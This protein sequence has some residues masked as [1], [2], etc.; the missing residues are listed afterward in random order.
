MP[1]RGYYSCEAF[2][3]RKKGFAGSPPTSIEMQVLPPARTKHGNLPG[4]HGFLM[5][6]KEIEISG[7]APDG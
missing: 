3:M 5:G 1:K 7:L 6:F 2:G 4:V